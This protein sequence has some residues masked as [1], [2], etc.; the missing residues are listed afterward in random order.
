MIAR[1]RASIWMRLGFL[2]MTWLG[3][4][5]VQSAPTLAAEPKP[6]EV[7]MQKPGTIDLEQ[8]RK[9]AQA[10]RDRLDAKDLTLVDVQPFGAGALQH[11]QL[12]NGMHVLLAPDASAPVVAVHTWVQVGSAW[13]S[14]GKTGLAHL[15][16]HLMFK[17]TKS[18][19]AGTFDRVLEQMGASANAA[20]S[21]DWT[22][23]HE[24][25]P[26][27]HLETVLALE[28]DR[29]V[30]LDLTPLAFKSEM[31]VVKNE[32]REH[33]DNDVD[34]VLDEA[35]F[36]AVY[37][38]HAYGHPTIGSAADLDKLNLA[39]VQGF[40]RTH[41]APDRVALILA[42]DVDPAQALPQIVKLYGPLAAAGKRTE[43][44]AVALPDK[45]LQ[46]DLPL[47][48]SSERLAVAWRAMPGNHADHPILAVLSDAL[49]GADSARLTRRL[50]YEARLAADAGAHLPETKGPSI[51]DLRVALLPGHTAKEAL[52]V[53]DA[54]LHDLEQ[55]PLTEAE[56]QGAKNRLRMA[57]FRELTGVDGRAE[58]L[59]MA[60]AT[61]GD[62]QHHT[63]WWAAVQAV[64]TA[65]L[66]RV[67]RTWLAA[68]KRVV[69][70]GQVEHRITKARP[71]KLKKGA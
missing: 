60:W 31:E 48:A 11:W 71:R 66:Q 54:G 69:V 35:V 7:P 55:H 46:I 51:L 41:Y 23:Y 24:T 28:A 45:T 49:F 38:K 56:L 64:T 39:D 40:Y 26:P 52:T 22:Y 16:E 32:R 68:D 34:G 63:R 13:E 33:V 4:L 14:Q 21:L 36:A 27:Q 15:L 9:T 17:S 29:L 1:C 65:D 61:F 53:L 57:H 50:V 20:T 6:A 47:D 2:G 59:G 19:P 30:H 44:K 58:T 12:A 18:Q 62:V 3:A 8:V 67:A 5:T 10:L 37:G 42:G 43:V 25:V 70:L